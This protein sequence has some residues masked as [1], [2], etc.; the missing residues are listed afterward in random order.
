MGLL[1]V[2]GLSTS[3]GTEDLYLYAHVVPAGAERSRRHGTSP[4]GRVRLGR[5]RSRGA[6]LTGL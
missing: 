2:R 4:F 5:V 6:M 1:R 3:A